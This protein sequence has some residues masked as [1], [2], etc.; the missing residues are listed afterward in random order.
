MREAR[1]GLRAS[2]SAALRPPRPR[3]D[4]ARRRAGRRSPRLVDRV[5]LRA[6]RRVVTIWVL[7]VSRLALIS[8]QGALRRDPRREGR[9]ARG[10]L[11]DRGLLPGDELL[12][13]G[14]L[15]AYASDRLSAEAIRGWS[16]VEQAAEGRPGDEVRRRSRERG[17]RWRRRRTLPADP[18]H[19]S[20]MER[21]NE[22]VVFIV[23]ASPPRWGS[24]WSLR[25]KIA[26]P[27]GLPGRLPANGRQNTARRQAR[28]PRTFVTA[29][30]GRGWPTTC[31]RSR[32]DRTERSFSSTGDRMKT[33]IP[34]TMPAARPRRSG[35][36]TALPA[37][38]R[39]RR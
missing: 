27:P 14:L 25:R 13:G 19:G 26:V 30:A 6:H 33:R 2:S 36:R 29:G 5:L 7:T 37:P 10:E 11:P 8:A 24:R 20:G 3:S 35:R 9:L 34:T 32:T 15:R 28:R 22:Q 31:R 23:R 16:S 1:R 39:A 17:P 4:R 18:D 38:R 12:E 21:R